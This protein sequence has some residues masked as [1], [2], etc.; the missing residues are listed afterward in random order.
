MNSHR[1]S[2][3][4]RRALTLLVVLAGVLVTTRA[5]AQVTVPFREDWP[6]TSAQNW[7]GGATVGNPGTGG[8]DGA[9]DGY[10]QVSRSFPANLGARSQ[11]NEYVGDWL[12]AGVSLLRVALSDVGAAN[13]LQIHVSIGNQSDLWQYNAAFV[14]PAGTWQT[15]EVDLSNPANFTQI[16]GAGTSTF[17]EALQ[18]VDWVLIRHDLA[19]YAQS[20]DNASGDFGIDR[21]E[22]LGDQ[23]PARRESFGS[24]K[25]AYRDRSSRR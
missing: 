18:N 24:L 7:G 20:P 5:H 4:F 23:T 13:A 8:A 3:P 12:A 1:W 9:G 17:T 6:G 19:P 14:P 16:I 25:A 2:S 11:G 21:L 10:L 22:L 15:F